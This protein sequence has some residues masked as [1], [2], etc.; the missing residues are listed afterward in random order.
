MHLENIIVHTLH[1]RPWLESA[2]R[3]STIR[4]VHT[5]ASRRWAAVRDIS[6]VDMPP[7]GDFSLESDVYLC[8]GNT[9]LRHAERHLRL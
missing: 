9:L 1:T 5:K 4:L 7:L 3:L 8:W 6:T 2:K